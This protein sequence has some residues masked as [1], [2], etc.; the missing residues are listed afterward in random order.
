MRFI[1]IAAACL[2][3]AACEANVAPAAHP[4]PLPPPP[5]A[6]STPAS[7]SVAQPESPAQPPPVSALAVTAV[8]PA[9]AKDLGMSLYKK[10]APT[11]GNFMI[12]TPSLEYA[13]GIAYI[14][15]RGKTAKEMS[16]A[17]GF[18]ADANAAASAL[19]SNAAAWKTSAGG[20]ELAIANRLWIDKSYRLSADYVKTV[21]DAWAA[22]VESVDFQKKT[23][24]S[25][26]M[27]NEWVS[28]KTKNKI[29][30]LFEP[31]SISPESRL[32]ITNAIYFKGTWSSTFD[33]NQTRDEAFNVDGSSSQ[34][35]PMMHKTAE[36]QAATF[37]GGKLLEL[38][39]AKSSLAMDIFLPDNATGLSK[40]EST[41][42]SETLTSWTKRLHAQRVAVSLP[43]FTF[44]SGGSM[45]APLEG[46]G[47]V[48]AFTD[49][50]DFS[51]ATPAAAG[52][53]VSD[54]I[55]KT[56]VE[57]DETGTEAAAATGVVMATRAWVASPMVFKADH[58]FVFA[59]RDTKTGTL[60]FLGR[61][62]HP[63]AK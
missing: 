19:K 12:S 53:K 35:V 14:G 57:V 11:P 24:R 22:G 33:K 37:D 13:L 4:E 45:R 2:L 17:L 23:E 51:G 42:T 16:A 61:V 40:L 3:A 58:P 41:M 20:A 44:S 54:V 36:L 62:T 31:G 55:Q 8:D 7:P 43:R 5:V 59:I 21:N 18:D 30:T 46:M 47:M 25:R 26:L 52:L 38:G 28:S 56:F 15:A 27:I 48:E 34:N 9:P 50:A 1:L 29:P 10:L 60:L 49:S 63:K 32:V 6:P 39:Y